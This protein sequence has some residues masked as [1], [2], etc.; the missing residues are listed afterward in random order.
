MLSLRA[1]GHEVDLATSG[2]RVRARKVL[3]ATSAS[4]GLVSAVRRRVV[5]VW[6]YVLVTEPLSA[7]QL[8]IDRLGEIARAS[9]TSRTAFTTTG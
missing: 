5:P 4:P 1:D 6:D 7:S 3:L 9:A 8:R 2:G